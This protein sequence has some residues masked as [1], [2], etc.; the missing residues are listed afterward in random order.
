MLEISFLGEQRL[1]VDGTNVTAAIPQ[2]TQGL[3]A[4]LVLHPGQDQLRSSIAS[5]F[6][7]DST[8]EQSLTNLRRELH[9]LRQRVPEFC[10]TLHTGGS[11]IRWEQSRDVRCDVAEFVTA[12]EGVAELFTAEAPSVETVRTVEKAVAQYSGEL[13]PAW[14]DEW[15]LEPRERL[16]RTCVELLDRLLALPD[17]LVEL[18]RRVAYAARRVELE[19]FEEAGYRSLM[20]LQAAAGDRA[21]ALT[22]F[23]RCASMLERELGVSPDPAT[24]QLYESLVSATP[25]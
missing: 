21:A 18:D 23:H 15:V 7:P 11:L 12:A 20:S 25:S 3:I 1:A 9:A 14:V 19:P 2:R 8:D 17:A 16:H 24:V 22:T 4:A 5:A 13:L 10:S 6:W